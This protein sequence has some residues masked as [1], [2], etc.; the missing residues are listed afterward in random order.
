MV[1]I[2]RDIYIPMRD[3]VRI[4]A[5]VYLPDGPGPHAAV[6][7]RTPY[8]KS[9]SMMGD[10]LTS[11]GT[12][13][14]IPARVLG[15]PV[16]GLGPMLSSLS[17]LIEAGFAVIVSDVRG[18]G[19]S[20][21]IYDYYNIENGPLDGYD[22]IEWIA[23]QPWCDGNVGM[24][25]ASASAIYCYQAAVTH[26]P[27][28]K[29]MFVNMHPADYYL[30]Q[31]FVGGVFRWENR[32]GWCT[33]MQSRMAPQHPGSRDDPN[34][35]TKRK[36]YEQRYAQYYGRMKA[37]KNAFNA[38]WLTELFEHKDYDA[39][40][41]ERSYLH[42]FDQ[43]DV[44]TFHGGVWYDHFI[45]GTLASHEAIN[46]PKKLLVGPGWHGAPDS[47]G[48]GE[49]G[50]LQARWFDHFLR[51]ND[52]GILDE[53]PVRLY[54]YGEEKWID[55]PAW[56]LPTEELSLYFAPGPGG[57]A[58]SLN[59][60]LL[61]ATAPA[62]E[63]HVMIAHDPAVPNA[64]PFGVADQR[65]FEKNAL[66][67]STPPLEKDIEVVGAVRVVLSA[68]TNAPDV[69]WCV[70][71]CDVF[72][73]GRSRLMN[74]GALK[75]SHW[76]SHENPEALAEG[77]VYTFDIEVWAIGNVFKK[78][79][80]IRIDISNSDFPF[81]ETNPVPSKSAVCVGGEHASRLVLPVV[82]R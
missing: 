46:V 59:D 2:M 19:H 40:W 74:T 43:V 9:G 7:N 39:F 73:D 63:S 51:G 70:R 33:G 56:P 58:D 30:D 41:Q 55:E 64:T 25:G 45:R 18:T 57:G 22:S 66:T 11:R 77:R 24:T 53:P 37:G 47:A 16:E 34:Y 78:G 76:S 15:A 6:L 65:S 49:I 1:T 29:A 3:G 12:P 52:T 44:P 67:F 14:E 80:R 79:H 50:K 72:E 42:R 60:G 71:L 81:F 38:D 23:S 69:D 36:V 82:A 28:L 4:S 26:P 31:W 27:A 61:T 62:G 5:D 17:P 21:G 8:L 35:E 13:S 20:E 32:I 54:L 48:D 10:G 68:S 75:G